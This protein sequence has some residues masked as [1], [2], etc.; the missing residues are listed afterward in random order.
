M[1]AAFL[2]LVGS[3][4]GHYRVMVIWPD[5]RRQEWSLP[6]RARAFRLVQGV[7]TPQELDD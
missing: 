6:D 4:R 7:G 3:R 5:G 1:I 2:I